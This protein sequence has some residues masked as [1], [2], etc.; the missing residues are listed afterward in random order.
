MAVFSDK[1]P[2]T[3]Q[4]AQLLRGKIIRGD[5]PTG[6]RL[7]PEV[8][9]AASYGVS[10]IT[11]QRA[12]RSLEEDGLINRRRGRGTFVLDLPPHLKAPPRPS[13]L[14]MM[15]AD[16]FGA[17]TKVLAKGPAPT[18]PMWRKEFPG[19]DKLFMLSRLVRRHG[20][21]WNYS[22]HYMRPE[23]GKRLNQKHLI[24]YPIFRVLREHL[25]LSL[26][27]IAI[28]LQ[29]MASPPEV[30]Q[31]LQIDPASPVLYFT[32][33]LYDMDDRLVDVTE[34]YFCADGFKFHIDKDLR[35]Q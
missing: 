8:Q 19:L 5:F 31:F 7:E 14:E 3:Y 12:L 30:S 4:L 25:G 22:V 6:H 26:K 28:N 23:I 16:E 29:A 2:I 17:D 11:V 21:P 13:S 15:F 10:V 20:R 9:L 32:A 35:V 27:R 18:P 24:R 34:I 1:L 33:M